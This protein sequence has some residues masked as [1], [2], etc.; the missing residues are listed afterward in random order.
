MPFS[1]WS[2]APDSRCGIVPSTAAPAA[3]QVAPVRATVGC[4]DG[5]EMARTARAPGPSGSSAATLGKAPVVS[6][7]RARQTAR[8]S[9]VILS[10]S[11]GSSAKSSSTVRTPSS[12]AF[13]K[14]YGLP[15]ETR[16]TGTVRPSKRMPVTGSPV[17]RSSSTGRG[18]EQRKCAVK[19]VPP[20]EVSS[21]SHTT[22]SPLL[23]TLTRTR[24]P[25]T[26]GWIMPVRAAASTAARME[27]PQEPRRSK[28][29]S[30]S[31]IDWTNR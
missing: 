19:R 8:R 4:Q 11:A 26:R 25:A 31:G 14:R 24:Q 23:S 22:L 17:I 12:A 6:Q 27:C 7:P 2:A 1:G 18:G 10:K 28:L 3:R 30:R 5:T 29:S 20:S 21:A 9:R 16:E 15:I 13:T